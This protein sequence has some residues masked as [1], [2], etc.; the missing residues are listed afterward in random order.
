[1]MA[2]DRHGRTYPHWMQWVGVVRTH[3]PQAPGLEPSHKLRGWAVVVYVVLIAAAATAPVP[4]IG[5]KLIC[6]TNSWCRAGLTQVSVA[7][8]TE[9]VGVTGSYPFRPDFQHAMDVLKRQNAYATAGGPGTYVTV[10]VAGALTDDDPRD[11]SRIEGAIAGQYDANHTILAGDRLRLRLVL[12]N[13]DSV[14]GHWKLVADHL[15]DMVHSNDHLVGVEGMGLSQVETVDAMN[16]LRGMNVP[17]VSDMTTADTISQKTYP[18]FARTGPDTGQQLDVLGQ[19]LA[20]HPAQSTAMKAMLVAFSKR[21]DMYTSALSTDFQKYMGGPLHTGGNVSVPFGEDPGPEF[22]QIV[23]ILCGSRGINTV[24]YAGRA[25]DLPLFLTYLG[26]RPGCADGTITVVTTSDTSRLLVPTT[27]NQQAWQALR[28]TTKPLNLIYTPLAD[29][30]FLASQSD[31]GQLMASLSGLFGK[32]TFTPA[33]LDTGWAIMAHDAVLTIAQA[34]AIA[35][36]DNGTVPPPQSVADELRLMVS[37][38]TAVLGAS[39]PIRLDPVTGDR[40][41]MRIPVLQFVPGGK[42]NVLGVYTPRHP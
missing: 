9:L 41:G 23:N 36:G 14:E 32:L 40:Y 31:S 22:R 16:E 26:N 18:P 15:A 30:A 1:M 3:R 33:D 7:G 38:N 35:S 13:M 6:L 10:A 42:Q 12:G 27:A 21:T 37:S 8:N 29:P 34:V 24:Y 20:Q 28:S 11:L 39:G 5:G 17:T 25:A 2:R 19:Y 4:A